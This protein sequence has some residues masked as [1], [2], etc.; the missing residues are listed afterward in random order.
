MEYI[1]YDD[2][3]WK[4]QST[5]EF[6]GQPESFTLN[7][8]R[9]LI[10][11]DGASSGVIS[12]NSPDRFYSK[13]S[14]GGSIFGI[15][16]L[17]HRQQF[18]AVVG[19]PGANSSISAPDGGYNGGGKGGTT[20]GLFHDLIG[21]DKKGKEVY[22]DGNDNDTFK[23]GTGGGG[24]TDI[25]LSINED[26][27]APDKNNS[28]P[29]GYDQLT[30]LSSNMTQHIDL[31]YVPKT[32]TRIEVMCSTFK[33]RVTNGPEE[34]LFGYRSSANDKL[35]F[36]FKKGDVSNIKAYYA[37]PG[38]HNTMDVVFPTTIGRY[39][40]DT[41][42]KAC[43]ILQQYDVTYKRASATT[44]TSQEGSRPLY[45]FA[46]NNED[47]ATSF[48]QTSVYSI[49]I[50]EAEK[51]VR[52]MIPYSKT[53]TDETTV[54]V[55]GVTWEQ[56]YYDS[57]TDTIISDQYNI[58]SGMIQFDITNNRYKIHV[59]PSM[60]NTIL[61]VLY[62]DEDS[63]YIGD[64]D[65]SWVPINN[66]DGY[67]GDVYISSPYTSA[68][69][70]RL[71]V[72]SGTAITPSDVDEFSVSNVEGTFEVGL[73]D[74]INMVKYPCTNGNK[75]YTGGVEETKTV[76]KTNTLDT[77][78]IRTIWR[79]TRSAASYIQASVLLFYDK[80]D[81]ELTVS[82][83]TV[84]YE[85]G[86]PPAYSSVSETV[87][88]L[89]VNNTNKMCIKSWSDTGPDVNI[90]YELTDAIDSKDIDH[91]MVQTANDNN[92]RDPYEWEIY[93]SADGITWN[94][95][96]RR[97]NG[98][99]P[100]TRN[101]QTILTPFYPVPRQPINQALLSRIF[102]A[103][104][105]GG[106]TGISY[107][108][109]YEHT[110]CGFGGGPYGTPCTMSSTEY[111]SIPSKNVGSM[112]S[113]T[114]GYSFGVGQDAVRRSGNMEDP[115][116]EL[117]LNRH[118][119]GGGGGG[120]FGGYASIDSST[121]IKS[122]DPN[123]MPSWGGSGSSYA[124]TDSSYK[125]EWYMYGFEYLIDSL[126]FEK[127]LMLP[128]HAFN[129]GSIKIYRQLHD[130]EFPQPGDTIIIPY[131]GNKQSFTLKKG[132]YKLKCWGGGNAHGCNNSPGNV[133]QIG[134]SE[135]I[136]NLSEDTLLYGYVGSTAVI[137]GIRSMTTAIKDQI[138]DNTVL[139]NASANGYNCDE[140]IRAGG[141]ATDIRIGTDSLYARAIVAGGPG[142]GLE[143][144]FTGPG[145][146]GGIEG[147]A[148][149]YI[150]DGENNG[151]GGQSET[152]A[153]AAAHGDFGVGGVGNN[154]STVYG[155]CG[156]N[157]WFGGNGT[158]I[159]SSTVGLNGTTAG[160]GGSGYTL[161]EYSFK[162]VGYLLDERYYLSEGYTN[163]L[164]V[165]YERL[166]YTDIHIDVLQ[167]GLELD[168]IIRDDESFKAYDIS[169]DE[170]YPINVVGDLTK[171]VFEEYGVDIS[172]I[173]SDEGLTNQYRLFGYDK[174][175]KHPEN[176][177]FNIVPRP[178]HVITHE[179]TRAEILSEMYDADMDDDTYIF[180]GYS[181]SG[182]GENRKLTIDIECDMDEAP[183]KNNTLYTIQF[184]IRNKPDS[185]YYPVKPEKTV[186]KISLLKTGAGHNYP[187][188]YKAYM[189]SMAKDQEDQDVAVSSVM[190]SAMVEYKR[191]LYVA[192]VINNLWI[193]FSR[194]NIIENT[195]E[196]LFDVPKTIFGFTN[197]NT[198]GGGILVDDVNIYYTHSYDGQYVKIL[199]VPLD[200]S[201]YQLHV[202]SSA[203]TN[204]TNSLGQMEWYSKN[205]I[206]LNGMNG[207]ILFNTRSYNFQ[208]YSSGGDKTNAGFIVGKYGLYTFHRSDTPDVP[209]C[210]DKTTFQYTSAR[211]I[212]I[213]TSGNII[214]GCAGPNG[215]LYVTNTGLLNTYRE[216]ENGAPELIDSMPV[217]WVN[218]KVMSIT[219][220]GGV[221]Y[222]TMRD[223]D[224]LYMYDI[225]HK[226]Y[227]SMTMPFVMNNY[228]DN[229]SRMH[230]P[231]GFKGFFFICD[232]KMFT[233]NYKKYAKYKIGQKSQYLLIRT[234][235][236]ITDWTYDERFVNID[237]YGIHFHTGDV[238]FDLE[239]FDESNDIYTTASYIDKRTDY[240][241][242]LSMRCEV[243]REEENDG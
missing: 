151:G 172:N 214:L 138:S 177:T 189:H 197:K 111:Q 120:W 126:K 132:Q 213:S 109:G 218:F 212:Q 238:D 179:Y 31:N 229:G 149:T 133:D 182:I 233:V 108:K 243:P 158:R 237:D 76:Y 29:V 65:F 90:T 152:P 24:A 234:N 216:V 18:Y 217:P 193:R 162:P 202:A 13:P 51:L 232:L 154:V 71:V 104:G 53:P 87:D 19:G 174:Y 116:E 115:D 204:R 175:Q 58:T 36:Q 176:V 11:A 28:I 200:G 209:R 50:F 117:Y 66:V 14:I 34:S 16:N 5:F 118:G 157:G 166:V 188:R 196:T 20:R 99:L 46:Y 89:Y 101:A 15:L 221:L 27:Q 83:A 142:G 167:V 240:T 9:Y 67:I 55:S 164:S 44:S 107:N 140:G 47:V 199:R 123:I 103:C 8:D 235:D 150:Y 41:E 198:F 114:D 155:A 40:V 23:S 88:N 74:L 171:E 61:N 205:E 187:N 102:V 153:Q 60:T 94:Y 170:W 128:M 56:G 220:S 147:G 82:S 130:G 105:A 231:I 139:F 242:L 17:D 224:V 6:T 124:L 75:L 37:F 80:D 25:R 163:P 100:T 69:Y 181:I 191:N 129:G 70:I 169:T 122:T 43:E 52:W 134:Y 26:W 135:G 106:Q 97:N 84:E 186:E 226:K 92:G 62:F 137:A 48:S 3:I 39:K 30:Y 159:T 57:S 161:S 230:R 156:G 72:K 183:V 211:N 178:L 96:D 78:Y 32:N 95:F 12:T 93:V 127:V 168:V 185:Y 184:K 2:E 91:Y 180:V 194:F 136:L 4:P 148:P 79:R 173:K 219:Y 63:Q 228:D 22:Q 210:Y 208:G 73:Y 35:L 144:T 98:P 206:I 59:V 42:T 45:L 112:A 141:G 64:G 49:K 1:I 54:G 165:N 77:K 125:P 7:P 131:T 223:Q 85:N 143:R 241:K 227:F 190:S 222:F 145:Y 110:T 119:H 21:Y 38:I 33:T 203:T 236:G 86:N 215:L 121:V 239:L 207:F 146:G 113:Q 68:R 81:N 160:A 195:Y 192:C 10:I 225:G 201:P